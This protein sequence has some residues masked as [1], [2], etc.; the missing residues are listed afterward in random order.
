MTGRAVKRAAGGVARG[1]RARYLGR[2]PGTHD[3]TL[4][5]MT[6]AYAAHVLEEFSFDWKRWASGALKLAMDWPLFYLTN[7]AV[8]VLGICCAMVGWRM[9]EVALAFPA[10]AII[11]A[12]F[13]HLL[14]TLVQGRYSPGLW[15]ALVLFLPIGAWCYLGAAWDE[16]LTVRALVVSGV[17]GAL[18]MI[19]PVVLVKA[20]ARSR[21]G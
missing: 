12:L 4:W 8:I 16:V 15:T 1:S 3:V 2:M 7:A 17:L 19:Y 5:I 21:A 9:P 10:L 11:N 20:S 6:M 14:P 18:L 13:L